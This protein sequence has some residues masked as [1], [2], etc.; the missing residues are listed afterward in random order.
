MFCPPWSIWKERRMDGRYSMNLSFTCML[1]KDHMWAGNFFLIH[2]R[3][4]IVNKLG[5]AVIWWHFPFLYLTTASLMLWPCQGWGMNNSLLL[6]ILK[7]QFPVFKERHPLVNEWCYWRT[8]FL[9]SQGETPYLGFLP[10]SPHPCCLGPLCKSS[11][12]PS[13]TLEEGRF[14]F[15]WWRSFSFWG[16]P[17]GCWERPCHFSESIWPLCSRLRTEVETSHV[18]QPYLSLD[19]K[20]WRSP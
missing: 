14:P 6:L 15:Y 11:R 20:T 18:L 4:Y 17:G 3:D 7:W 9:A 13:K 1:A 19:S 12:L 5:F 16:I 2:L 8:N 10:S